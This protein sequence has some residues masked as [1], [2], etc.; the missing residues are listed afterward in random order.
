MKEKENTTNLILVESPTKAKII[1]QFLGKSFQVEASFGHVRDLP[2]GKFGIDLKNNFEPEYVIPLKAKKIIKALK[3][4]V[5]KSDS[6][7]LAC[8]EDRE[9]EAISWHLAQALSLK[10]PSRIVFHEITKPAIEQAL[11][12]PREIDMNLVN[13]QQTR[14][15]LDRIVGYKLS[16]FLWKKVAQGLSAGRV[17]SVTVR[18]IAEREK[19]INDFV[20]QEYWTIVATLL[21]IKGEKEKIKN[22][23]LEATLVKEDGKIIAKLGIKTK[24]EAGKILN[25]LESAA[26][27]VAKI[28]RREAKKSPLP[29]FTT[30]TLQQEAWQRFHFPAKFTMSLAQQLYEKGLSTYHRT[31][32]LNLSELSLAAAKKYIFKNFGKDYWPD[33]SRQYRTKSKSAQEAHEAIRPTLVEKS[34]D[35]LESL[36]EKQLK[37]YDLIWRRF[38][39]CQMA[40]AIFDSTTIEIEAR[41]VKTY[42][43]KAAGQI[44]K[45][46]GFLKA[47]PLKFEEVELPP[48]EKEEV[49]ELIRLEPSQHFTQPPSRYSEATLVKALEKSGIGRPSTY[50]PT[51]ETIQVRGYV[52]KDEKKLFFPTDIGILVNTV[53]VKHFPQIVDIGFTAKMEGDLDLISQGKK[54]WVPTIEEFYLPFK[55]NLKAKEKEVSKKELTQEET[56]EICP[57]CSSPVVIKISRYGKF[58]ACS[59][60]PACKYKKNI[61]VSLGLNCPKCLSADR[62]DKPG[63]MI[64]R[65]T[66]KRK[67]FYGCSRWPDCDFALWDKP[68]G[69]NCEQCGFLLVKN[70]WGKIKCS[71]KECKSNAKTNS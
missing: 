48:L 33:F 66:R 69:E 20:P 49:L 34:P 27:Q 70:K 65:I 12:N 51:L 47:Y 42:I 44:L 53:L 7:I 25:N 18:L 21:K 57:L 58:Y 31:D 55:E 43:F 28:E 13:A 59:N 56:K 22:D 24:D 2:E 54:E 62:Q 60:F 63:E 16:P 71:N 64:E 1:S 50:A 26:W 6:V 19:Q 40:E 36:D 15:I 67:I 3:A 39:A 41:S 46:D 52:R 5:K 37:L 61:P 10:S 32:S 17:Q 68:T 14:R 11:K 9:G 38:L 45:F 23:E 30:S 35:K 8:D 29:P 4:L